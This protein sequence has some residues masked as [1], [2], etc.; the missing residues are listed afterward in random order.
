MNKIVLISCF[1]AL[2]LLSCKKEFLEKPSLGK[3]SSESFFNTQGNVDKA[4]NATYNVLRAQ[5]VYGLNFWVLGSIASDDAEAGG[6]KGGNDQPN[7]QYIDQLDFASSNGIFKNYWYGLYAGIYRANILI[8][9]VEDNTYLTDATAK[10]QSL[11]QAYALRALF[12]FEL[13]KAFGGVPI[14]DR[15]YGADE[16]DKERNT[17]KETIDQIEKDLDKAASLLPNAWS[18]SNEGRISK[19]AALAL[20]VKLLVFESSY[21]ENAS[22]SSVNT[23]C[24]NRW[25]DAATLADQIIAQKALYNFDLESN[26]ADIWNKNGDLSR[27]NII[28]ANASKDAIYIHPN[29]GDGGVNWPS[30]PGTGIEVSTW[31]GCRYYYDPKDSTRIVFDN[32][33]WQLGFGFNTPT[34]VL[35]NAYE[36]G[37]PRR[38][39]TIIQDWVSTAT[40]VSAGNVTAHL[41]TKMTSPTTYASRKYL[42]EADVYNIVPEAHFG[43][44]ELDY[45]IYRY[46]DFLL[47]AAEAH[48]KAGNSGKALD[49]VNQIR[50]RAR[51]SGTTGKPADLT[52]ITYEKIL[53]ERRLELACEGHRYF[54]VVR[55][56]NPVKNLGIYNFTVKRLLQFTSGKNEFFPIPDEEI[57]KSGYVIKQ[58]PGY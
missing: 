31:Q 37:D 26:F 4:L 14:M 20:K 21:A 55:A 10:N 24:L 18:G 58:N 19:G 1:S 43:S 45:K 36:A 44:G 29:I 33:K 46:A 38:E 22:L 57:V 6:E 2:V 56:G 23:G 17:I 54:D 11:G 9:N 12:H 13:L 5:E 7:I 34:K 47:L 25:S 50:T 8:E 39:S 3:E 52:S 48:Y 28:K 40:V 16:L 35:F 51:N 27:E 49:L 30:G 42:Q 15:V 41:C 32:T 53:D